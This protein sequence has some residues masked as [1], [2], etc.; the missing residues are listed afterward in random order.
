MTDK[1]TNLEIQGILLTPQEREICQI[2]AS[3]KSLDIQRAH[4]LLALDEG[5]TQSQAA[6]Q[7]GLTRGQVKYLLGKFREERLTL[8]PEGIYLQPSAIPEIPETEEPEEAE[9]AT[10]ASQAD[11]PEMDTEAKNKSKDTKKK[12]SKKAKKG[13]KKKKSKKKSKR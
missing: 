6:Q 1:N 7:S 3:G 11:Q 12:K 13:K 9:P 10:L 2:L 4:A 5:A 8:F